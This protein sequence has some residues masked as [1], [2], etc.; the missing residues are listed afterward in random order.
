MVLG[1]LLGMI[2]G[3]AQL[4]PSSPLQLTPHTRGIQLQHQEGVS[5]V[6]T[7]PG[8][9]IGTSSSSKPGWIKMPVGKGIS[10]MDCTRTETGLFAAMT[11]Q[12]SRG[13]IQ[14]T[15]GFFAI[16]RGRRTQGQITA[17]GPASQSS[18]SVN[19]HIETRGSNLAER[20]ARTQLQKRAGPSLS[21]VGTRN[22]TPRTSGP[23]LPGSS[24]PTP[25]RSSA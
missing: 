9:T 13:Q 7:T 17:S 20:I 16:T 4:R 14:R 11:L 18:T 6:V 19:F 2:A 22:S 5:E 21:L 10:Q 23:F 24:W 3:Q 1:P 15:P 25:S 8:G 12:S